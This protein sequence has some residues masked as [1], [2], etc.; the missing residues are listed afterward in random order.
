[1]LY[2]NVHYNHLSFLG[3]HVILSDLLSP[4]T[5]F[6]INPY[7]PEFFTLDENRAEKLDQMKRDVQMYLRRNE[8]KFESC[9]MTLCISRSLFKRAKDQMIIKKNL[10]L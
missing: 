1:M 7:V 9:A 8:Y 4:Y 10:Y 2:K 5:Y 3:T 6:R